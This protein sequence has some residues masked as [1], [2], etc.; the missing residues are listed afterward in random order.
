[1]R[2]E[3]QLYLTINNLNIYRINIEFHRINDKG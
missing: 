3:N 2:R 1:M